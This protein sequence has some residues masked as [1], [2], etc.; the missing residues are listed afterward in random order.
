MRIAH[1]L[2]MQTLGMVL[3]Y[4]VTLCAILF[5]GFNAQFGIGW[6][7]LLKSPF[8][9]RVDTIADA[10]SSN[11]RTSDQSTW[12]DTLKSFDKIYNAEFYVFDVHGTELAGKPL[13]M[14]KP[15]EDR[16]V[17]FPPP[18]MPFESPIHTR[19]DF[20]QRPILKFDPENVRFD[21]ANDSNHPPFGP[22]AM[23]PFD[24][25]HPP[26]EPGKMPPF[27]SNHPPFE[28][29][30]MPPFDSNHPPFESGKMPPFDSNHPP[31]EPGKMPPFD[32]NHPP[33]E[34]GKMPEFRM[35][36]FDAHGMHF[37]A[38]TKEWINHHPLPMPFSHAEGRFVVHT[39][40]P[41]SYFIGTKVMLFDH[42]HMR[43]MPSFV[44][45][46]T[47]A[48]WQSNL[49]FDFRFLLIIASSIVVLSLV[50][51][52]PFVYQIAK[53]ISE[54]TSV[55]EKIAEGNFEAQSH[56]SRQDELGRLSKS[57]NVMAKK[58]SEYVSAQKRFLADI[59]H[60]L[61]SPLARLTMAVELLEDAKE[62]DEP[63][64]FQEIQEEIVEM[65]NLIN[66][67]LA[68]SKAGLVQADMQ[69]K[70]V[71]LQPLVEDVVRKFS[72]QPEIK[73]QLAPKS[74]VQG[75]PLLLSRS[76]SNIIRNS[77]RYAGEAG[78]ITITSTVDGANV[79]VNF[80][81][82]G[83]GV[84]EETIQYL[85]Q[86]FFRPEFSRNRSV[87]GFGLGL[88]IVKSCIQACN[89]TVNL[90]NRPEGGLKVSIKLNAVA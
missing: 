59:S 3:L 66:E 36:H 7:A 40:D 10:I 21:P 45:A 56:I 8:G 32:S 82:C 67:L 61:Y 25:N 23:P 76:F 11:M 54:L 58:L 18:G 1:S 9:D 89:G 24:S 20:P 22:G 53:S 86:P 2:Y 68:Y 48:I 87:G 60:E 29:G 84:P 85:G 74:V 34:P 41:D 6:E 19:T 72:D 65:R 15:L 47:P 63:R 70:E 33:F 55:T 31:F 77:V 73:V 42:T 88:A 52:W 44:I 51:W 43:P 83:P 30:K 13:K 57:V 5:I 17:E 79:I 12:N 80:L 62:E 37:D 16:V 78:P 4:L 50:F 38:K 75:D 26:F 39:K 69:L 49:I 71:D 81:D 46:A 14:P 35:H 27:D 64:H 90:F 28:P